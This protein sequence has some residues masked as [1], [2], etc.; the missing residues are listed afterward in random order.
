MIRSKRVLDDGQRSL[1]ERL[2]GDKTPLVTVQGGQVGQG[3]DDLRLIPSITGLHDRQ[4]T[5][6]QGFSGRILALSLIRSC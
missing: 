1:V 4:G 6:V 3:T 2:G 5:L